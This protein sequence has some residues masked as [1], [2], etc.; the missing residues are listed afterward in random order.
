MSVPLPPSSGLPGEVAPLFG[1]PD[2][3][4]ISLAAE[5]VT[6]ASAFSRLNY[7]DPLLRFQREQQASKLKNRYVFSECRCKRCVV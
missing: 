7:E 4:R 2:P 3:D 5:S 6:T 1:H